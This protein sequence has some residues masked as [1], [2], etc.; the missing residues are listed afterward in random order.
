MDAPLVK[1][2]HVAA[3]QHALVT[4]DQLRECGVT[5]DQVKHLIRRRLLRRVRPRVYAIVGTRPTWERGILAAVLSVGEGAVA[6]HASAAQLWDFARLPED[7]VE[8][9][10]PRDRFPSLSGITIHRSM[11]L[12]AVDTA[13]R[14]GIPCTAF[15]RTLSDCTTGLSKTQLGMALDDGLR[16]GIASLH[17]LKECAERLESGPGRHMSVVR[18]LLA[19][20]GVDFEPGG[21]RSEL[22]VLEV[23]R[24]AGL[25]LPV[26]QHPVKVGQKTYRLDYAY[27]AYEIL[28]EYY[29]LVVHSGASAVAHDNDRITELSLLGWLPLIFTDDTPDRV[30]VERVAAALRA[31]VGRLTGT[32]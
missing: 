5:D 21:S 7:R 32:E 10:V 29:G 19:E 2:E 28:M 1:V 11:H 6:S 3:R 30:I 22:R 27:P 18:A 23:L 13:E 12:D 14:H 15:E 17:R 25:P 24:K 4:R 9:T 26:Q 16:R 31:R 20:R 8:I